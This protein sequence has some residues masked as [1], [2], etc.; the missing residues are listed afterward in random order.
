[1]LQNSTFVK[2]QYNHQRWKRPSAFTAGFSVK[3]QMLCKNWPEE[4]T[5]HKTWMNLVSAGTPPQGISLCMWKCRKVQDVNDFSTQPLGERLTQSLRGWLPLWLLPKKHH[6]FI[7]RLQSQCHLCYDFQ[8]M[9]GYEVENGKPA[10][11]PTYQLGSCCN[12]DGAGQK[13]TALWATGPSEI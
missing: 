4:T 2:T 12:N 1:M 7:P 5:A 9:A 13:R 3:R 10:G 8:K 11:N 6:V